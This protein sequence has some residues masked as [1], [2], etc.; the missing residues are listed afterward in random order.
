MSMSRNSVRKMAVTRLKHEAEAGERDAEHAA[1]RRADRLR[2]LLHALLR[3]LGRLAVLVDPRADRRVADVLHD[4]GQRVDEVAHLVDE[5]G[6]HEDCEDD[7]EHDEPEHDDRRGRTP[8][9]PGF[10]FEEGNDGFEDERDEERQEQREDRRPDVDE[11]P[12]D[13]HDRRREEQR[14]ERDR[15]AQR[16]PSGRA[17]AGSVC[18]L[19]GQQVRGR[20]SASCAPSLA[21]E[22]DELECDPDDDHDSPA[23]RELRRDEARDLVVGPAALEHLLEPVVLD[24]VRDAVREVEREDRRRRGREPS[25]VERRRQPR[26]EQR[27]TA[28]S[29]PS[30]PSWLPRCTDAMFSPGVGSSARIGSGA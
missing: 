17:R 18:C 19:H 29:A 1:E 27:A 5:R 21:P 11:R 28:S 2:D 24:Q 4:R 9:E 26:Q 14:A 12:A 15:D 13:E 30:I 16:A 20:G 25:P 3:L 8:A 6:D 10:P 22:P 23:D 7:R